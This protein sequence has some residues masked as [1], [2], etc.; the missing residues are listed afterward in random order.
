LSNLTT[1]SPSSIAAPCSKDSFVAPK[2]A[3]DPETLRTHG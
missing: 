2:L 1:P 3:I